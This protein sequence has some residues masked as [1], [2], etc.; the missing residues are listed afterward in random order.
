MIYLAADV[1]APPPSRADR[2]QPRCTLAWK[3]FP[4]RGKADS[5]GTGIER[6]ARRPGSRRRHRPLRHGF[7][8]ATML[9]PC[10]RARGPRCWRRGLPRSSGDRQPAAPAALTAAPAE[11]SAHR[12]AFGVVEVA[13]RVDAFFAAAEVLMLFRSRTRSLSVSA[14]LEP[15]AI[16]IVLDLSSLE[17]RHHRLLAGASVSA[18]PGLSLDLSSAVYTYMEVHPRSWMTASGR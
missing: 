11:A 7:T 2:Q 18:F 5:I 12:A 1:A 8:V 3:L 15:E 17:D 14:T 4:E 13:E 10:A 9:S 16:A 6:I